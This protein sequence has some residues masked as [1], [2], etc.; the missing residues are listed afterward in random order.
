[1]SAN[2][3]TISDCTVESRKCVTLSGKEA[4]MVE[5]RKMRKLMR[6]VRRVIEAEGWVVREE[7]QKWSF[8]VK[9]EVWE[10]STHTLQMWHVT[11]LIYTIRVLGFFLKL[12]HWH[13]L[14]NLFWWGTNLHLILYVT[15]VPSPSHFQRS[16]TSELCA[17]FRTRL[18]GKVARKSSWTPS[19][20]HNKQNTDCFKLH[21]GLKQVSFNLHLTFKGSVSRDFRPPFFS[22]FEPIQA[23]NKQA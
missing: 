8:G 19:S 3:P 14:S 6:E 11:V 16:Y 5:I 21:F 13:F 7:R 22:W 12:L 18:V 10:G 23:P 20:V 15:Y 17:T 2:H 1:M 4:G 9:D